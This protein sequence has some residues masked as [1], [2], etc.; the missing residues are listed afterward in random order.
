M[1]SFKYHFSLIIMGSCSS[2]WIEHWPSIVKDI[3][4]FLSSQGQTGRILMSLTIIIK[5]VRGRRFKSC[6]ERRMCRG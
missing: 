6:Q 5:K 1:T 4:L 3:S 2:A